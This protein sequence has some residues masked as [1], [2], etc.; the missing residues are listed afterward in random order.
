M[1]QRFETF[2]TAIAQI[3][4]SIQR[5]KNREMAAMGLKGT[6]VMCVFQ[7][8]QHPEGLTT[9][10]LAQLCDEDKAAVS[11][12]LAELEAQGLTTAAPTPGPRR[13][14]TP[15]LLT[16]K[17]CQVADQVDSRIMEAVRLAAQG[18]SAQERDNFYRV[19]LQVAENLQRAEQSGQEAQR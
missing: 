19:L 16:E 11:R 6:H 13:Y 2:V 10:Q 4:R 7:L 3:N 15:I 8:R 14:R 5:I 9:T 1:I 17:G 12:A 18:Y